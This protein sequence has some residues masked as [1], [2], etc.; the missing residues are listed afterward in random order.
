MPAAFNGFFSIKPSVGRLPALDMPN[1]SP[2]QINIQ[3]VVGMLGASVASPRHVFKAILSSEPW[4]TDPGVLPIP[5]RD[6]SDVETTRLS[7]AS[8]DLDGA[9]MPH[10]QSCAL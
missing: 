6:P 8:M 10:P 9:V 3:T 2:G 1:P 7:F 5:W 4:L